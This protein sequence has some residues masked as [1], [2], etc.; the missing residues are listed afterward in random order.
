[1]D[2]YRL[3]SCWKRISDFLS[4]PRFREFLVFLFFLAISAVFWMLQTLDE[5]LEKKLTVRLELVNVPEGVVIT[6]PLPSELRVKVSDKGTS[7]IHYIRYG[8]PPVE[9]SFNDVAGAGESGRVSIGTAEAQR[10]ISGSLLSTSRILSISPDTLEFY[11]NHGLFKSVPVRVAG[12]ID[13]SSDCY[14]LEVKP[15]PAEV[16]VYA[17][18]EVLDTL[19]AVYTTPLSLEEVDANTSLNVGLEGLKGAKYS[20]DKVRVDVEVD[21]YVENSFDV[22]IHTSNFPANK[23]LTTFPSSVQVSFTVGY[24]NSKELSADDFVILLTYEEILACQREG[25]TKIPLSLHNV[26]EGV[27]NVRIEPQ[28]VD[29]LIE[30]SDNLEADSLE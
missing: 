20:T 12:S 14:L 27:T 11:F 21:V 2:R 10:L 19:T 7:L 22:P 8:V 16:D 30:Q 6:S 18:Q 1:M 13:P 26:P 29:Y 15:T 25:K 23:F 17:T 4:S 24:T 5:T 9:V 28:E 3:Q